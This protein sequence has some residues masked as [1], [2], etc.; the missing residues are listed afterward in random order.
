ML[1]NEVEL[2][3]QLKISRNTLRQAITRWLRKVVD[4]KKRGGDKGCRK[5]TSTVKRLIG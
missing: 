3:K 2:S 1:P 4:T 5:K